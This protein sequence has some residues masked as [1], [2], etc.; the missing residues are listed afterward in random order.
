MVPPSLTKEGLLEV[1]L[2]SVLWVALVSPKTGS[3]YAPMSPGVMLSARRESS[4]TV[5]RDMVTV[6]V[7]PTPKISSSGWRLIP[8]DSSGFSQEVKAMARAIKKTAAPA[9]GRELYGLIS[10][11]IRNSFSVCE[12]GVLFEDLI[13][14]VAVGFNAV[15]RFTV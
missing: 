4:S 3:I 15:G 8:T 14:E 6:S 12:D 2:N 1:S 10:L 7:Y 11:A 5:F 13:I 9:K